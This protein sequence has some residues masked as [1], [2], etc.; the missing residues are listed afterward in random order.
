MPNATARGLS[1]VVMMSLTVAAARDDPIKSS[2]PLARP[3]ARTPGANAERR[4]QAWAPQRR[5]VTNCTRVHQA[6][7]DPHGL[8]VDPIVSYRARRGEG[9][10]EGS[11]DHR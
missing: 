4:R 9:R 2:L 5:R 11:G 3:T 10:L 7:P 8:G 1:V 6:A